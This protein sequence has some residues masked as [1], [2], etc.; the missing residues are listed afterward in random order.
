MVPAALPSVATR[1]AGLPSSGGAVRN[2]SHSPPVSTVSGR[3]MEW[4]A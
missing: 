4:T 1:A 2:M 3:Q